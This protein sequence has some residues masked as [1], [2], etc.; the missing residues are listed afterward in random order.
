MPTEIHNQV[1]CIGVRWVYKTVTTVMCIP[2]WFHAS[3]TY[4]VAVYL[5]SPLLHRLKYV[6]HALRARTSR[7]WFLQGD[8]VSDN[9][10]LLTCS[11]VSSTSLQY[12]S[13]I[14]LLHTYDNTPGGI[15]GRSR[16]DT[17]RGPVL[18]PDHSPPSRSSGTSDS[19]AC[20]CAA[21]WV[22]TQ[23]RSKVHH[24]WCALFRK[25]RQLTQDVE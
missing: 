23:Y 20:C 24:R 7:L 15:W 21:S 6:T 13:L 10:L 11:G 5:I 18:P 14:S 22:D 25:Q 12:K 9:F 1:A 4:S 17:R 2:F 16:L 8:F 3:A 19:V